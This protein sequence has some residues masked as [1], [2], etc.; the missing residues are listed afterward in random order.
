MGLVVVAVASVLVAVPGVPLPG[1][2]GANPVYQAHFD[3]A[4]NTAPGDAPDPLQFGLPADCSTWH[5]LF[6]NYSTPHHQDP[7]TDTGDGVLSPCDVIVLDNMCLHITWVGPTYYTTCFPPGGPPTQVVFE[8]SD[9]GSGN[10]VCQVW[11]DVYPNYCNEIHVDS[12]HD[13]GNGVLDECDEIDVMG[14]LGTTI[15]H[16]DRVSTDIIVVPGPTPVQPG[17]WGKIKALIGR[18]F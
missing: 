6:P 4:P 15:Y 9:P 11:H 8:P 10:P 18:I 12:W 14:P 5:E 17:T 13:N 2:T 7:F 3:L 16:I 1:Q